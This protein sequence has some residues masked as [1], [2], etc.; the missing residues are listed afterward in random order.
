MGNWVPGVP[1]D[2]LAHLS[3][4]A[5]D[6]PPGA[7]RPDLLAAEAARQKAEADLRLQKALR[8]PDPT[9]FAQYEH[10]P[11]DQPNTVGLGVSFPLPLW[12]RNRGAIDSARSAR[13]QADLQAGKVRAQIVAEIATARAAFEAAVVRARRYQAE[14]QPKSAEIRE[15]GSF[16]FEKGGASLLDLLSAQRTDNEV[17]LAAALALADTATASANLTAALAGADQSK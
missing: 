1:L 17:R 3:P 10:Q 15:T 6:S 13:E 9:V 14:I 16:A 11:P 5:S 4:R 7:F 12:N 8:V 2:E